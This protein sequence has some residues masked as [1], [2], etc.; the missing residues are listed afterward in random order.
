MDLDISKVE[1][2]QNEV[3]SIQPADTQSPDILIELGTRLV[4]YLSFT[5]QQM[6]VSKKIMLRK[7][8]SMYDRFV[9]NNTA[10]GLTI[11]PTMAK[12]YVNS[13]CADEQFDYDLCERANRTIVHTLDFLRSA[14]SALKEEMKA[15]TY[16]N[17]NM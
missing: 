10:R 3:E 16:G 15:S 17:F 6:A 7:R 11:T 14:L 5:G 9:F 13:R 12:D 8:A 1:A 4:G 2:I